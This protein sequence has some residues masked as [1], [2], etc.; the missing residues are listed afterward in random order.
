MSMFT[1]RN[2]L[3]IL[4]HIKFK[5]EE[6]GLVEKRSEKELEAFPTEQDGVHSANTLLF[7]VKGMFGLGICVVFGSAICLTAMGSLISIQIIL[8]MLI[9]VKYLAR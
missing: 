8:W 2:L 5:L 7:L 4:K 9:L 6:Y 1:E 3:T